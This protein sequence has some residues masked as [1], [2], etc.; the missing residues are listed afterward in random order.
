MNEEDK[1]DEEQSYVTDDGILTSIVKAVSS[2]GQVKIPSP[3]MPYQINEGGHGYALIINNISIDGRE[4]RKGAA[5]D[6]LKLSQTMRSLGY[7]LVGD[8]VHINC[9]A[10]VIKQLIK[11]ATNIDHTHNDS[12]I[13]CLMSHGDSDYVYGTDDK[14]VYLDSI[15]KDVINCKGLFG[16]PKI[17]FVQACRGGTLPDAHKVE[18][19]DHNTP[20]KV[21]LPEACDVFF[22]YATS[23]NTK[24]CR[25]T[26]TGSWYITELCKA[27][28]DFP[29]Q[30]LLTIVQIAQHEVCT[31]DEYVYERRED[32]VTKSYKQSPQ[33]VST[34]V[35]KVYFKTNT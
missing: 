9:T 17:F 31:K 32:K 21:L 20:G 12:F 15:Q 5:Q 28:R 18:V 29:L 33:M 13:C 16:K 6:G 30:D 7:K 8:K 1:R 3:L 26:D 25:F 24:A 4:E 27:F 35:R 23:P 10:Y 22:G 11:E 14:P 2:K 34:L 19:D